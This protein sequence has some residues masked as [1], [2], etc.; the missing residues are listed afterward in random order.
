MTSNQ[1][2]LNI[3]DVMQIEFINL[4]E[5]YCV[6][7]APEKRRAD[8][9]D[10]IWMDVYDKVF[11]PSP[12]DSNLNNQ[13][14]KLMT[15]DIVNVEA[16]VNMYVK[17]SKR[18]GGVIKINQFAN[19]T[20]I[21]RATLWLWNK[22]NTTSGYILSLSNSDIS[23]ENDSIIYIINN[24]STV[25]IKYNGNGKYKNNDKLSSLR[26]DVI[27]KLREEMQDSNTNGLSNDTMGQI[28]RANNEEELGKLY[29]PKRFVMQEQ[30]KVQARTPEQI[31]QSY[32]EVVAEIPEIPEIPQNT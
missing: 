16:V 17:L 10:S 6:A 27:K 1:D 28:M 23:K 32:S 30:A 24:N 20:G 15:Y 5:K 3:A 11:K 7:D 21:H 9:I 26:F 14:S 29:E 13:K 22:A 2:I 31:A 12:E 8:V 25:N 4:Y 19:L 18:F